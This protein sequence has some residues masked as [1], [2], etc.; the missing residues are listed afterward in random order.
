MWGIATWPKKKNAPDQTLQLTG[1][2]NLESFSA[3]KREQPD[4]RNAL[5]TS[6]KSVMSACRKRLSDPFSSQ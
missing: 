3:Q 6:V 4:R 2:N 1:I 5:M